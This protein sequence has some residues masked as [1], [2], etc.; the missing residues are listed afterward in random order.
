MKNK[1]NLTDEQ[2]EAIRRA[3]RAERL[4]QRT[5]LGGKRR[6]SPKEAKRQRWYSRLFGGKSE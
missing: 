5:R 6:P 1:Q 2:L 4:A 3:Q